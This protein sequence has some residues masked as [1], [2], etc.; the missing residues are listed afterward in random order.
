[1]KRP[2]SWLETVKIA[3]CVTLATAWLMPAPADAR[4]LRYAVTTFGEENLD[5][6][7]TSITASLGVA[8]PLW[9]W[10]TEV[11][12]DGKLQPG[13]AT[14]W[15]PSGDG[16][17]WV[18]RLRQGVKFHDGKE[19]TAEDVQFSLMEAFRR[20]EAKSS[21]AVQFRKGIKDVKVVDRYTV[22]I[23]TAT[24]WPTFPFDISNQPGIEGIVLPKHYVQKAG[25][26]AF[27]RRPMGTGAYKFVRHEVGTAIEFEAF[28]EH[29][30]TPPKFDGL[31]I[32]VVP[33]AATRIAMLKTGQVDI[34]DV[35]LD[36]VPELE[37]SG[38]KIAEDPQPT[39]VRI[40]LYGTYYDNAGPIGDTRVRQALNLAINREEMVRTLFRG[41]GKPAAVFPPAPISIGY[42]RDLKPYPYDPQ[43]AKKLLAE[44]G[45]P[46]GFA[47]K[48]FSLSTGGFAQFQQVAEA[49]AGYWEAI[50]VRT[51]IVP[52]DLGAFRPLYMA[53]PQSPQVVGQAGV[54]VTTGRLNGADDL[55]I[56][57]TRAGKITQLA[58]NVEELAKKAAASRTVEEIAQTVEKAFQILYKDYRSVPIADVS[59]TLWAYGNQVADVKVRPHR[60]YITP[61][62]ATAT[63][64][65]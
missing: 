47:I 51:S 57:W 49:V 3:V 14:T 62:L 12:A 39:S 5:P 35:S 6:T 19:M 34:A 55:N 38:L 26:T 7:V 36:E 1:M 24:P 17:T 25:W 43:R 11:T 60:G 30:R 46:N 42:P 29:W 31:R 45:F 9:D 10:L 27:A 54:F 50:G 4:T 13:L 32:I 28:K 58:N 48:L 53:S 40:H 22:S 20:P 41:K 15:K 63:A 33:E 2:R 65:R 61:S 52:T 16:L 23:H 64:A 56:W 37:R 8:G 59:G 44:A 18:F 21:R